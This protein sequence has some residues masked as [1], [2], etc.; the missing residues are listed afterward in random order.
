M[1]KK[2]I[3]RGPALSRS[4][5]GEQTRFA[6]RSLKHHEDKFDIYLHTT[7]WGST[8]WITEDNEERQW[9]DNLIQKTL[10]HGQTGGRF[11]VSLQVTIPGEWEKLAPINI[12]YTAGIET[13][14]LSAQWVDKT[15]IM[16][17][18]IVP[19]NHS[20][21]AFD[22]TS[23]QAQLS[24]GQ[25]A[26]VGCKTPVEVVSFPAKNTVEEKIELDL[27]TEFNFLCV[28]QLSPRKNFFNTLKW[29]VEEF[30]DDE[31]V[32]IVLKVSLAK[33]CLLDRQASNNQ[34]A[35]F[36]SG[37]PDRKCK[38]YLLHGNIADEQMVSLY[39]NEKIKAIVSTSHGEGFGLPLFEAAQA[40]LP[41][42]APNWGGQK[43]FLYMP[44]KN[45]KS[46][47]EKLRPMFTKVEFA[48]GAVQPEAV[49]ENVI[50]PESMWCYPKERS[51]KQGLRKVYGEY[52]LAKSQAK[53]LQKYVADVFNEDKQY[54]AF[55]SALAL[56]FDSNGT[57]EPIEQIEVFK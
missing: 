15:Y 51:F 14:K 18:I 40:G 3:V 34:L 16:D 22:T 9:M 19:S 36:M 6:L 26:D 8:S 35:N 21:Y 37:Y 12:G 33:G 42:I 55:V 29:F 38:V 2:I 32:G 20:K 49:W 47:K 1:K 7:P 41:V 17:K 52:G 56:N 45:K 11:D 54:D 10:V 46:K 44:V 24:N 13:T 50:I 23:W 28:A 25:V 57:K 30:H 27:S 48:L 39:K 5:Y 31:S 4:G 53:K 43:D